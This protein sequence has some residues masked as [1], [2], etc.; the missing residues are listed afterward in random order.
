MSLFPTDNNQTAGANQQVTGGG[1]DG[2]FTGTG[3]VASEGTGASVKI[4]GNLVNV[5]NFIN[6]SDI[7]WTINGANVQADIIA[8]SVTEADLSA[9]LAAKINR[10]ITTNLFD[11]ETLLQSTE[12]WDSSD[13]KIPTSAAVNARILAL[14]L[15]DEEIQDKVGEM[16]TGNTQTRITSTYNDSTG[17][18]D[19]V[20]TGTDLSN[21]TA[22]SGNTATVTIR[23]ST[24][25][26]TTFTF[27]QS[28]RIAVTRQSDGDI[29]F[30][31]R[32]T[33]IQQAQ[34]ADNS[35]GTRNIIDDSIVTAA[36]ADNAVQT[37]Q[38]ND[39][40]VT[41]DKLAGSIANSKLQHDS[42]TINGTVVELGGH[43]NIP[44]G[45]T[46][47]VPVD[48]HPL[49]VSLNPNEIV[50]AVSGTQTVTATVTVDSGFTISSGSTSGTAYNY[51]NQPVTVTKVSDTSFTFVVD[52][53]EFGTWSFTVRGTV[54]RSS[55]D[56]EFEH[57]AHANV[58]VDRKW[59]S[60][61]TA[62]VPA[63]VSSMT[64]NGLLNG[65]ETITYTADGEADKRLYLALPTR[66]GGYTLTSGNLFLS[67]TNVGVINTVYTLYR[68]D[69]F[70]NSQ[71][72]S[73]LIVTVAEA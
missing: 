63:N 32:P 25:Q 3:A 7:A 66:S 61:I 49:K 22:Q 40:A 18:I 45:G 41:N 13:Q 59:Y 47:V 10:R 15:T 19:L 71:N 52:R 27:D 28:D 48:Q 51:A 9:A 14:A 31:I 5:I 36:I 62:S 68:V 35:I 57:S 37:A 2:L 8:G 55:D 53:T 60:S 70:D 6:S 20:V 26:D 23:S 4:N 64:D 44:G 43:I 12:T 17:K 29:T 39:S 33:S 50:Y 30:D 21:A 24:G 46:P 34:M 65:S 56:S 67:S 54:V 38:I 72:G 1:A 73:T 16:F 11:S 42:I 69:D 58:N